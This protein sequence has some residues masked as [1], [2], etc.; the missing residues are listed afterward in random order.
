M[1]T[2]RRE[3]FSDDRKVAA[4]SAA[5]AFAKGPSDSSLLTA[6]SLEPASS[7]ITA[8]SLGHDS[9][10]L[11]RP[12]LR[13]VIR[14]GKA[15]PF[16]SRSP[17]AVVPQVVDDIFLRHDK[18]LSPIV[19]RPLLFVCCSMPVSASIN[20]RVISNKRSDREISHL[21]RERFQGT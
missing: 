21:V 10:I 17:S 20:P 19:R 8:S 4:V 7:I 3:D 12:T 2:K 16:D 11:L 1:T 15:P 9:P 6:P 18:V 14:I 13:Y 5:A